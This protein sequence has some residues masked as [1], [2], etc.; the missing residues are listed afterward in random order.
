MKKVICTILA[1]GALAAS[2]IPMASADE[3]LLT[4]APNAGYTVTADGKNV[5]LGANAVYE[6]GDNLMIPVRA[7]AESLGFKVEWNA[8]RGGI[9]LDD[10]TVNTTVYL[11]DDT[12]YMA[13]SQAIGMSAPTSLGAAPELKN[14]VT[15]VPAIPTA[16]PGG[17]AV[18]EIST[19]SDDFVQIFYQKG[20]NEILYRTAKGTDDI[21]GDYNVYSD[22]KTVKIGDTEV[23]VRKADKTASVIW[24]DGDY[25]YSLYADGG[26]TD[27]ELSDI[28]SSI[29]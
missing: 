26:L 5:D 4:S 24:T 15:F 28:I 27:K 7:V 21:S 3:L 1:C 19:L 23:T 22:V 17:Y 8:E 11:N 13:S 18:D 20:D 14:S 12:Y 16:V 2:S 9:T 6:K 25:S 29:R 10:G